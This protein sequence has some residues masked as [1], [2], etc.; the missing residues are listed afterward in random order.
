MKRGAK[1]LSAG[2]ILLALVG[3]SSAPS[4]ADSFGYQSA[5]TSGDMQYTI[6]DIK[7]AES[8]Y[9]K[10]EIHN[11]IMNVTVECEAL[12]DGVEPGLTDHLVMYDSEGHGD[13]EV[14]GNE[15][16]EYQVEKLKAGE[17]DTYTVSFGY[18][19]AE[20]WYE[21]QYEYSSKED[22]ASFKF[23]ID[24]DTLEVSVLE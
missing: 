1:L 16:G 15:D 4:I 9:P 13:E 5:F 11:G 10:Y 21:L 19:Y 3:C 8:D 6:T 18:D 14:L 7:P 22:P 20:P 12:E 23:S 24:P 2:A 17:T